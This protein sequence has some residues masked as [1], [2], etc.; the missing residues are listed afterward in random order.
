VTA[1][2]PAP[3][4]SPAPAPAPP[5]PVARRVLWASLVGTSLESYDFYIFSYFS[6]LFAGP[7]FFAPLGPVGGTLAALANIGV[8]FVIRPVGAIVFGHLGDRIGRRRTLLVTILLM[9]VATGLIGLLPTYA[10]AGWLGAVLLVLLRLVQ[11]FSLGGEWAG[12]V[13][14]AS[15]HA[16]QKRHA[17][18]AAVPQLGSPIGS[19]ASAFLLIGFGAGF[20]PDALGGWAWRIPFLVAIPFLLV[21]LYLRWSIDETPVFRE[22][23]QQHERSRVPVLDALRRRPVAVL[24]GIAVALLGIGSYSL[25]NTYTVNYG[26]SHLGF[27][28]NALLIATSIGGLLQLVTIPLFGAWANR[29]GSARVVAWGAVATLVIAFP[30]YFLLQFATFPIL[31]GTMIVGGILPT[32]SWAALGG[33]MADLFPGRLRYAAMSIAYSIAAVISGFV[34][35]ITDGV[36]AATHFAWWHPAIVLG[37]MSLVTAV[38]AFAAVRRTTRV[39]EL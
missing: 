10:M 33:L 3:A 21:S 15:E 36:G 13:L 6:A 11:G 14:L 9:G 25:M 8:G 2:A 12:A 7:L 16:G 17:F 18:Y 4:V 31:V 38:A 23:E 22:L 24:L 19:L 35:F 30:M 5:T 1:A 20:G 29:I 26:V 27:S 28:A 32:A 39:D 34:P 37:I